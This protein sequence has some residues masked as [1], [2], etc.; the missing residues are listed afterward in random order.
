MFENPSLIFFMGAFCVMDIGYYRCYQMP[1]HLLAV[2]SA[3]GSIFL[4]LSFIQR[5]SPA[6]N[7]S[8]KSESLAQVAYA[9]LTRVNAE[10]VH[11]QMPEWAFRLRQPLLQLMILGNTVSLRALC[12]Q[13]KRVV[14]T[15]V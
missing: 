9:S 5:Q 10:L 13:L 14:I 2:V 8:L 6:I 3:Q 12:Q 15:I 11:I 1:R 4:A 7:S